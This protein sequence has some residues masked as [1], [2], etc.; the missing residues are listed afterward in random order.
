MNNKLLRPSNKKKISHFFIN[1][2]FNIASHI[3][4][5][6]SLTEISLITISH[7]EAQS[8]AHEGVCKYYRIS[9]STVFL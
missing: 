7:P 2:V 3:N 1:K 6:I 9:T 4:Y 8:N 5:A